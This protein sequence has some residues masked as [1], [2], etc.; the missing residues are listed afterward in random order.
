MAS[1]HGKKDVDEMLLLALASGASVAG[2]AAQAKCSERTVRRRLQE[3][4]FRSRVSAMRSE[5]VQ[6]A[7]GRLATLG[8][9]AADELHRLIQQGNDKIKLGACRAVLGFMLAGH[10]SQT[11]AAEVAELLR[12]A[13]E[14]AREK[15][16]AT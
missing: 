15:Q 12:T 6:K 10:D 8:V 1:G 5:M 3:S 7:V 13:Q 14:I 16:S 4:Q 2:A 11:L 9:I